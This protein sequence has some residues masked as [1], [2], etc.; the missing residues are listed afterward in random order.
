MLLGD[1]NLIASSAEKSNDNL[2]MRLLGQFRSMIQDL[3]L[4]DYPLFGR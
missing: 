3:E 2:N 4:I 1:F